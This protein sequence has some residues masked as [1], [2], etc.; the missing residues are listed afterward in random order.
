MI[1]NQFEFDK[2]C[3]THLNYQPQLYI[4]VYIETRQTWLVFFPLSLHFSISF[5]GL[6]AQLHI[7]A[8]EQLPRPVATAPVAQST[9]KPT[10]S[11]PTTTCNPSIGYHTLPLLLFCT[12]L[13][14][15][16]SNSTLAAVW[17]LDQHQLVTPP[18]WSPWPTATTTK[19][20]SHFLS[21][22]VQAR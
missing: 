17:P 18:D 2:S 11:F 21:L 8:T 20:S 16:A 19:L 9:T 4:Q 5:Y 10:I 6:L 7:A 14:G 1:Y 3:F 22:K 15:A 12:I 13:L